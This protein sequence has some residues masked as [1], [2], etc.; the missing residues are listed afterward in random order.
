[1]RMSPEIQR[2]ARRVARRYLVA[3]VP[4]A[5]RGRRFR[6][7]NSGNQVL[8]QSLPAP[9]QQR[10]L[11]MLQQNQ[12]D[13][14][15]PQPAKPGLKD[16]LKRHMAPTKDSVKKLDNSAIEAVSEAE[17]YEAQGATLI[18]TGSVEQDRGS[19]CRA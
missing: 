12:G 11:M 13:A 15:V 6:N 5:F 2:A 9:E 14:P 16:K 19:G 10:L 3:E 17:T 8:F 1:M 7:P 4:K 18:P